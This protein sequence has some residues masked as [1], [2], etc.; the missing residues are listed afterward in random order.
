MTATS[1][2]RNRRPSR[3]AGFTLIELLVV[4][5]IIGILIGLLLPAVQ[6]VRAAAMRTQCM[7]NLKQIGLALHNF[8]SANDRFPPGSANDKAPF[9]TSAAAGWGSS[10]WVYILPFI[11]QDAIYRKWQFTGSSGYS[12]A[13]NQGLANGAYIPTMK[14]RPRPWT[15][16]ALPP[17]NTPRLVSSWPI[18]WASVAFGTANR[19]PWAPFPIRTRVTRAAAWGTVG[20]RP[21]ES[22]TGRARSG[23]RISWTDLQYHGGR[24]G[25]GFS[26]Y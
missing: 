7:N 9:G 21:T 22:C 17:R 4:I 16:T 11:E 2:R 24:R 3:T 8:H 5:A 18:T 13:N 6:K 20:T 15:N 23:S 25:I 14:C 19:A 10:W 26:L 1:L 12:N